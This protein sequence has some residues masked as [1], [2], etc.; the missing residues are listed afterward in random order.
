[1]SDVL[2]KIG[3]KPPI[4]IAVETRKGEHFRVDVRD[5]QCPDCGS[6]RR[7]CMRPSGHEASEWHAARHRLLDW[8]LEGFDLKHPMSGVERVL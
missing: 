8:K 6:Q 3:K 7:R 1:M 2:P 5:L 4:W